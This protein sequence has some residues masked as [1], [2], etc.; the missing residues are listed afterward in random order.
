MGLR[1]G[2]AESDTPDRSTRERSHTQCMSGAM[3]TVQKKLVVYIHT[4]ELERRAREASDG[5]YTR[6]LPGRVKW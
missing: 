6:Y 5:T 2:G 3:T 1:M 4:K